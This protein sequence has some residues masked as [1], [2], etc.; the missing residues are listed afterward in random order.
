MHITPIA[1][2]RSPFVSKFGIPRQSG[3]IESLEGEVIFCPPYD[4]AD[5]VRGIDGF[6]HLW[7]IWGFSEN[8]R[9]KNDET[10]ADVHLT[11]RPPRLGGNE[12]IG[13]FA[14]RSPFRP[15]GLGLS[16]VRL[17]EIGKG[18]LVVCGADLMD[19]TPIYDIKPYVPYADC[20]KEATGGYTDNA[21]R[22]LDVSFPQQLRALMSD[23]D[24][25]TIIAALQQ[26][27]RPHYHND[28]TRIYGM[29][30][31]NKDI[32]FCVKGNT[33]EVISVSEENIK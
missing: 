4:N 16:C 15:N 19:G 1:Y 3:I 20:M 31:R 23:A 11:V 13:V 24:V 2:F 28:D 5:A 17:K 33:V 32:K 21:W 12:R 22:R 10:Q 26:D 18:R 7:L 25:R 27:P 30:Y 8:I 29:P 9:A 14:S 6:T